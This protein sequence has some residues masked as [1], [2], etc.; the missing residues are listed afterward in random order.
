MEPPKE[1][2]T[3]DDAHD[4]SRALYILFTKQYECAR[5]HG[6]GTWMLVRWSEEVMYAWGMRGECMELRQRM[7]RDAPVRIACT[8][9]GIKV[10]RR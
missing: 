2:H 8:R 1:L 7:E 10:V 5:K 3:L 4:L 6:H 9:K